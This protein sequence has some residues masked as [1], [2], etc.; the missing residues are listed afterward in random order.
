MRRARSS[1]KCDKMSSNLVKCSN[2]NV[3]INEVLA[4]VSNKIDVMTEEGISRICIS[5]FSE[6]EIVSAKNLL[7]DSI[8]TGKRKITRKRDGKK[9]RDIDDII[10][11]LKGTDP[12]ELPVFVAKD[13][14]KLPPVLFDHVDVTRLL[15]DIIKLQSDIK[16]I[17]EDYVT[18]S[19]LDIVKK[20]LDALKTCSLVNNYEC[21]V[22]K[23]RGA[24][25]LESFNYD[26]GPVGLPPVCSNQNITTEDKNSPISTSSPQAHYRDLKLV[27]NSNNEGTCQT[28]LQSLT[29]PETEQLNKPQSNSADA[30]THRSQTGSLASAPKVRHTAGAYVNNVV[31][32][33]S[34]NIADIVRHG[35]WKKQLPSDE[36]ITVQRKRLKNR[37][38]AKKGKAKLEPNSHF[39]AADITIPIY[40]YNVAKGVS[41]C[42]IASYIETK[43][44]VSVKLEKMEMKMEKEYDAYKIFIP[45]RKIEVFMNDSF[46]PEGIS[47][48]RFINFGHKKTDRTS[49]ALKID[50]KKII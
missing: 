13:L 26:S 8:P 34:A 3:V 47:F 29:D 37:F 11:L 28:K 19:Q 23:K 41:V 14:Q 30:M 50:R 1:F 38:G 9:Q 18:V 20:D 6:S 48:R 46:W 35:E 44:N 32:A 10:T 4:F 12:D 17:K 25:M 49:A 43:A 40:I 42:D 45:K 15:K 24:F 21:N 2:C 16:E 22:N 39:K 33:A 7:F 5:A 36:W 31:P 27:S